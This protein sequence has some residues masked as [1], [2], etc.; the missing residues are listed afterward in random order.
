LLPP[1]PH[2][3]AATEA[4][5]TTRASMA[6]QLRRR[7]AGIPSRQT[8]ASAVPPADCQGNF[9]GRSSEAVAAVVETVSVAVAV[10]AIEAGAT[11]HVGRSVAPA[12]L[13][14]IEQERAIEPENPPDA[15]GLIVEVL[16][17]VAP[18]LTVMLPLLARVKLGVAA[19]VTVTL[20]V[21]VEVIAPDVPVT[22]I[23]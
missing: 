19:E 3:I 17:E 13:A 12:G 22:V 1:P 11:A 4:K 2:P 15:V 18:G 21:V 16:P 7:R 6:I 23:A 9:A 8:S 14:V 5:K 20:T 10:V